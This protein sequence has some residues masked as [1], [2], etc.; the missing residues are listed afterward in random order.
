[1]GAPR[2]DE[3]R[4]Q[5]EAIAEELADLGH[6]KLREVLDTDSADVAAEE[7]KLTRARRSVLKAAA[8]LGGDNGAEEGP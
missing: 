6:A 4:S 1:M 2:L 8:L 5:L 3:L 7:R